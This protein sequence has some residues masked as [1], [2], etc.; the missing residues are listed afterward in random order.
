MAYD[1]GKFKKLESALAAGETVIAGAPALPPGGFKRQA[2]GGAF[3]AIGAVVAGAGKSEAG[4]FTLP[5]R[6]VLGLT[7]QRLLVCKPDALLG[8]P[9][10]IVFDLPLS[11]VTSA[12]LVSGGKLTQ[13]ARF[14]TR[15][16]RE[17]EV[18]VPKGKGNQLLTAL[19][20]KAQGLIA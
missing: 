17:L 1:A 15:D 13:H 14:V 8:R 9:K 10:E 4:S 5:R 7:N 12:E 16:G 6:F 19:V 20:T 3:G 11:D 18:E 2:A